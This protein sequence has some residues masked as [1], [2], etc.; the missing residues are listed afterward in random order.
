MYCI[1]SIIMNLSLV[2]PVKDE[3]ETLEIL[4]DEIN[5]AMSGIKESDFEIIFID[6]GSTDGSWGIMSEMASASPNI[7]GMVRTGVIGDSFI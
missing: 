4:V 1:Q 3:E 2:I 6:D 5:A 7:H